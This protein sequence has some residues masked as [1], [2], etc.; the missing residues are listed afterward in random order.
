MEKL[1]EVQR[2]FGER[3][4]KSSPGSCRV[5]PVS[6]DGSRR[7]K[8]KFAENDRSTNDSLLDVYAQ[9]QQFS[10]QAAT[11]MTFNLAEF[12]K[13]FKWNGNK[14][15][16]QGNNVVAKFFP[17]SKRRKFWLILQISAVDI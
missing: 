9:R 16:K 10:D 4:M 15:E 8:S 12:V 1:F 3:D 6:L 2:T 14:L 7:V 17:Q 5:F 13:T 11:I